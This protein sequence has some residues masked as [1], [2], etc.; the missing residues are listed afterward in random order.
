MGLEL[1]EAIHDLRAGALERARPADV[2]LLIETGLELD[3]R[4]DR[5]SRFRRLDQRPHDGRFGRRPVEGLL[6]GD[7]VGVARGLLQELHH[8]VKGLVGMM[9][10]EILLT[11]GRETVAG[12][13]ADAFG[14]TRVVRH[15]FEIRP[16]QT[17]ELRQ[18][19]EREHAVDQENLVIGA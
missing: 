5:F 2:G 3:Q 1:D 18:F 6:D 4:G 8:D 10:N 12:V 16:I 17:H 15:E 9:N 14:I 7:H 19:V 11:N 13:I